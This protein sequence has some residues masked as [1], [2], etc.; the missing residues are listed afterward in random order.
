[1]D[2][3]HNYFVKDR[4]TGTFNIVNGNLDLAV[5]FLQNNQYFKIIGSVFND[6]VHQYPSD[7]LTDEVFE[8]QV[9]AMAVPP[10][11]IAL[12]QEIENWMAKYGESMMSPYVSESFGGYSYTKA[13]GADASGTLSPGTTWQ[14]VFRSRL[15]HWRKVI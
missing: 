13:S 3:I 14:S 5:P 4:L 2:Y 6:G 15:N 9:W 7:D 8:G 10:T 12:S 1:M 11:L